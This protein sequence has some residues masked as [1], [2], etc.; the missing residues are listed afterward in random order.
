[1]S[2]K[3]SLDKARTKLAAKQHLIDEVKNEIDSM[4][5]YTTKPPEQSYQQLE[6]KYLQ[7]L[8]A[9]E[10][11]ATDVNE[12]KPTIKR[13][14]DEWDMDKGLIIEKIEELTTSVP[15]TEGM[16]CSTWSLVVEVATKGRIPWRSVRKQMKEIGIKP[17]RING[18]DCYCGYKLPDVFDNVKDKTEVKQAYKNYQNEPSFGSPAGSPAGSP[19]GSPFIP[20]QEVTMNP[21][22]PGIFKS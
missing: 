19:T 8:N 16:A 6:Q 1:M 13:V 10:K 20:N 3:I 11:I 22:L 21:R 4:G 17:K 14:E 18:K 2:V 15:H 5:D 12:I 9:T 7:L